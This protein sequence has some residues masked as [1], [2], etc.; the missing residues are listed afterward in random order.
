METVLIL[1]V[2]SAAQI[3]PA[4]PLC[5]LRTAGVLILENLL[6]EKN[7][8]YWGDGSAGKN[9]NEKYRKFSIPVK[10]RKKRDYALHTGSIVSDSIYGLFSQQILRKISF[11]A[12]GF[13]L[14]I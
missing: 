5:V 9:L 14:I 13:L 2:C 6:L 7:S 1:S 8:V 10:I 12:D 4:E 11:C 3:R